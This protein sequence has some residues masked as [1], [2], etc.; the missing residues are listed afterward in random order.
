MILQT[1]FPPDIRVEK[2]LGT[3]KN[4]HQVF[5]LCA[6]R[7]AQRAEDSFEGIEIHRVLSRSARWWSSWRLMSACYSGHWERA[8]DRFV[9]SC[10]L[11]ALHVHDLPLLGTALR[12]ARRRGVPV[13]A[14]LHEN[15]PAMLE[16][17]MKVPLTSVSSVGSLV[18]RLSVSLE[19]WRAYERATVPRADQ[20]VTVIEEARD[21]LLDLG[22]DRSRLHV[23]ANYASEE[24]M[25]HEAPKLRVA[26]ADEPFRLVYA[27]GFDET[28]DLA[29]VVDAVSRLPAPE[30]ERLEVLLVGGSGKA[31]ETLRKRAATVDAGHRIQIRA[32][33]PLREVERLMSAASVGLVPHVKSAHTDATI[34]HKL[35]QYMWRR[36]PVI[37][38]NCVPL[39]RIVTETN[40]GLVY[41]SGDAERLAA[42]IADLYRDRRRSAEMGDAGH[43]AVAARYNWRSAGRNLLRVYEACA[44]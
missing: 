25:G 16:E 37:V 44:A 42:S 10:R 19:R 1:R 13:V 3:L 11:D 9:T 7:G 18:M 33:Q 31:L 21:R 22:V 35:F 43:E 14:D 27:G 26:G 4:E 40:C 24:E 15:Y 2:E 5:L 38:S 17:G 32:W 41:P 39:E 29:T 30:F 20:V 34:P 28:R 23:V 6:K 12:V 36:L 8:I